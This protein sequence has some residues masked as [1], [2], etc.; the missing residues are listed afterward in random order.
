MVLLAGR[1]SRGNG[2]LMEVLLGKRRQQIVQTK[3][4]ISHLRWLWWKLVSRK[5]ARV[6]DEAF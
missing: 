4:V 6:Y 5:S 3:K 1:S 2:W